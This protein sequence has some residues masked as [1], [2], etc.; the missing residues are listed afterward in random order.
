MRKSRLILL[1]LII[2]AIFLLTSCTFHLSLWGILP[3][4]PVGSSL[5]VISRG[6][7]ARGPIYVD[8]KY[9]GKYLGP[10]Q[11]VTIYNMPCYESVSVYVVGPDGYPSR[12][13]WV[14]TRPG[15]NYVYFDDCDWW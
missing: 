12:I 13:K 1:A 15:P 10:F 9:T 7:W 4:T 8:E 2:A 5:V 14:D 6:Y 11:S 3:T